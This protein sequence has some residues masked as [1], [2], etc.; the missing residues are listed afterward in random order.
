MMKGENLNIY[1][2]LKVHFIIRLCLTCA[3]FGIHIRDKEVVGEER[4]KWNHNI[5][6][7]LRQTNLVDGK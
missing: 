2:H 4:R 7:D 6:T 5:K 1:P 3:S